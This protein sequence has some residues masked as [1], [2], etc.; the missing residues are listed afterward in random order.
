MLIRLKSHPGCHCCTAAN[1]LL[2]LP[3]GSWHVL[4]GCVAV[5]TAL[6]MK[7]DVVMGMVVGLVIGMGL[8]VILGMAVVNGV[9]QTVPCACCLCQLCPLPPFCLTPHWG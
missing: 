3:A 4:R 8:A 1:L 5:G 6:V 7:T 2:L 9:A